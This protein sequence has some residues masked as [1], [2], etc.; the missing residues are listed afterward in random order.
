M[1]GLRQHVLY[2]IPACGVSYAPEL[3][4][5]RVWFTGRY[6]DLPAGGGRMAEF[7]FACAGHTWRGAECL[8]LRPWAVTTV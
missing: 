7:R 3:G 1:D 6:R 5:Q 2:R 4:N 8:W